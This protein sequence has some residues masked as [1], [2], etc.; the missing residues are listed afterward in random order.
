MRST[1][2][3]IAED[4]RTARTS[5]SSLFETAGFRVLTAENGTDAL[6]LLLS[7]EPEAAVL[8]IRMPGLDGL[9]VL[10]RAREGGSDCAL[11]IMTAFGD[12]EKTIEAMKLGAFDYVSKPLDFD[13][14]LTQI[15]RAIEQRTLAR[16]LKPALNENHH[17]MVAKAMAGN[18]PAMQHVYKLIGQV[19]ASSATVLVR[20][21]SGTGKELVV[22]ALH[23]NSSRSKG[24]LIKVNCASIPETLLESELFGHEKGAFTNALYRRV[25]RF[26]E[27]NSG[28]LFLD[29][30][31]EL[32]PALQSKLL[33]ALQERVIER[34]GSN[35]PIAVD[36]RLV[37]ATSRDLEALV[38][39]GTFRE[40]LYYRLNVVTIALPPLRERR[41]DIPV[42]VQHFM[43]RAA[44]S[45]SISPFALG[46]LCD[47]HWPGNVRE[48][49]N[50]IERALVLAR[51]GV[52]TESELQLKARPENGERRWTELVP[53]EEG[54]KAN[55]ASLEKALVERALRQADG[56]KSRA[57]EILGIH[58]RL[59][60]EKIREYSLP[61]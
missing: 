31:G 59:L 52:I 39:S 3:L 14:L 34:L 24:P 19:A 25:G 41:Q 48:L 60:Y 36:I 58:R 40:D 11:I 12:S 57:A 53:L 54:L 8:D 43:D 37:A 44:R 29:E 22:N 30:I 5:L 45:V 20:G 26:E 47:Y 2:I 9:T 56:N 4:E 10:R 28:T 7:E 61:E 15:R 18:S 1:T 33:R 13:I 46:L 21:E 35:M 6:S 17:P 49:E 51:T 23:H 27:A 42:L 50:V 16:K 38:S 55:V 32:A